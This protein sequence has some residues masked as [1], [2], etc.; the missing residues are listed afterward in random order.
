[1]ADLVDINDISLMCPC[2][3]VVYFFSCLMSFDVR[4]I[5]T[6]HTPCIS[7]FYLLFSVEQ[8]ENQK[9]FSFALW[10]VKYETVFTNSILY[11]I[12][13]CHGISMWFI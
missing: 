11:L 12:S 7:Y 9:Y 5:I 1:M 4:H 10:N 2:M 3:F 6:S 8:I 13:N